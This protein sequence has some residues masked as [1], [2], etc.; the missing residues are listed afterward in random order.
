MIVYRLLN[1]C[2]FFE[3]IEQLENGNKV[4]LPKNN[5]HAG[6]CHDQ[7]VLV[8]GFMHFMTIGWEL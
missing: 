1:V 4:K 6:T 3:E 8:T 7:V 2:Y 5:L